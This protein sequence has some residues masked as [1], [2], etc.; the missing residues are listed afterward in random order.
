VRIV[1]HIR[2]IE[3]AKNRKKYLD[4]LNFNYREEPKDLKRK[5]CKKRSVKKK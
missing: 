3:K 5:K 4:D 2:N 1:I